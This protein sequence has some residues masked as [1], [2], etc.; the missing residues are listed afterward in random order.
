MRSKDLFQGITVLNFPY[1]N[2]NNDLKYIKYGL[3]EGAQAN[4]V[5]FFNIS[6]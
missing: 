5:Y 2:N 4:V 3:I 1:F 6:K